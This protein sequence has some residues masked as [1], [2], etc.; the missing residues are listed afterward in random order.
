MND[1][2]LHRYSVVWWFSRHF[3]LWWYG[4]VFGG[5]IEIFVVSSPFSRGKVH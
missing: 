1:S 2:Y 3:S 4:G 5:D